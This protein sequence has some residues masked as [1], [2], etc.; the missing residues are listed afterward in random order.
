MAK[1]KQKSNTNKVGKVSKKNKKKYQVRNWHDYNEAL[2]QRGSLIVWLD[3]AA[4]KDER[5]H[6]RP[7]G[8]KGAQPVYSNLAIT[9]TL[10]FGKVFRQRLRQTEGL[11]RSLFTLMSIALRVPTFSTLC[12]RGAKVKI[13]LPK[14]GKENLTLIVDSTGLKVYGEG[15]WKVRKH[16]YGKH[17]TWRKFHIGITPD[18]EIRA[19]ELTKNDVGDNETVPALFAQEAS[20][21]EALAGDGAYDTSDVYN[22]CRGR[23]VAR[24]LI[25]P[26]RNAKIWQHGNTA[27]PPHPRDE[28]LRAIRRTSRT[29]WKE[30][31]GYH[32]RSLAETGMFRFKTVFGER[33][34]ARLMPQQTTEVLMKSSILNRMLHLGRPDSYPVAA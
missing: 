13:K 22:L 31:V 17:R 19:T 4:L 12:R 9:V 24:I 26:Q 28:N 27:A 16:G 23:N 11:V 7:S 15:E 32:I 29:R 14:D 20:T 6:A 21:I 18:G 10:Q 8:K 33:L 3:K 5:W 30:T 2:K 1:T 34:D 25:P